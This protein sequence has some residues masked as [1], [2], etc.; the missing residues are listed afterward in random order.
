M[1][2][3]ELE[4]EAKPDIFEATFLLKTLPTLM[5]TERQP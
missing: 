3:R 2:Y 5:V 1:V 4:L